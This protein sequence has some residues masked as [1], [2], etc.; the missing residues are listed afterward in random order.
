LDQLRRENEA[1]R[2]STQR[3]SDALD[4]TAE[5]LEKVEAAIAVSEAAVAEA[6]HAKI[7]KQAEMRD[8]YAEHEQAMELFPK[9]LAAV[10]QGVLELNALDHAYHDL[11]RKHETMNKILDATAHSKEAKQRELDEAHLCTKVRKAEIADIKDKTELVIKEAKE[12]RKQ[13]EHIMKLCVKADEKAAIA[14]ADR[15]KAEDEKMELKAKNT[16]LEIEIAAAKKKSTLLGREMDNIQ[17]EKQALSKQEKEAFDSLAAAKKL[18]EVQHAQQR[19]VDLEVTALSKTV[20]TQRIELQELDDAIGSI[21]EVVEAT[22]LRVE[23]TERRVASADAQA[24]ELTELEIATAAQ[25][26][27]AQAEHASVVDE[28]RRARDQLNN[29]MDLL[30]AQ[31]YAFSTAET[32]LEEHKQALSSNTKQR[33]RVHF[34][35]YLVEQE[36]KDVSKDIQTINNSLQS[37]A[38]LYVQQ[39]AEIDRLQALAGA[40]AKQIKD[41]NRDINVAVQENDKLSNQLQET[42]ADMNQVLTTITTQ[43]RLLE[44]GRATYD[45]ILEARAK[46][47]RNIS[48]L[49]EEVKQYTPG[50]GGVIKPEDQGVAAITTHPFGSENSKVSGA[51]AVNSEINLHDLSPAEC[52]R[53]IIMLEKELQEEKARTVALEEEAKRPLNV[54]RWMKLETTDPEKME[55]IKRVRNLTSQL[56]DVMSA[57]TKADEKINKRKQLCAKVQATLIRNGQATRSNPSHKNNTL[58]NGGGGGGQTTTDS[59]ISNESNG[60]NDNGGDNLNNST[61]SQSGGGGGNQ[62]DLNKNSLV[63]D[64]TLISSDSAQTPMADRVQQFG[65]LLK[66]RNQRLNALTTELDMYQQQVASDADELARIEKEYKK[67][68]KAWFADC[69]RRNAKQNAVNEEAHD[70]GL[71]ELLGGGSAPG[72]FNGSF[73]NSPSKNRGGDDFNNSKSNG[74]KPGSKVT[75]PSTVFSGI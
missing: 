21:K 33:L 68:K 13:R 10:E 63:G 72:G 30:K 37:S 59:V 20:N 38:A 54:H 57:T 7:L 41:A 40:A 64:F 23:A 74:G 4:A 46:L 62:D 32:E 42:T 39:S 65:S 71:L 16:A 6:H 18:V 17:Q 11:I 47:W 5:E 69:R 15:N 2:L 48:K 28:R 67:L 53:R 3:S 49:K 12:I 61:V 19:A 75:I 44:M 60:Q 51:P 26:K 14:E 25:L 70:N 43:S 50:S 55:A 35:Q 52:K 9:T 29:L 34:D 1:G 56:V 58:P 27:A 22:Q 66:E 24:A 45:S 31:R 8:Y 36:I 73:N